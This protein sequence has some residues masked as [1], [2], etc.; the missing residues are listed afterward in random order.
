VRIALASDHAG[1]PLK[2]EIKT[3]LKGHDLT[4][5]GTDHKSSNNDPTAYVVI[6]HAQREQLP[7]DVL[8]CLEPRNEQWRLDVSTWSMREMNVP[9][10]YQK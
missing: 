3:V 9:V 5:F 2:E 6:S 1:Y 4:D 10:H 8:P 7:A